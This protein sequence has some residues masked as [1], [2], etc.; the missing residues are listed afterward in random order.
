M[1]KAIK[2][3]EERSYPNAYVHG[4]PKKKKKGGN[5]SVHQ[6]F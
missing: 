2:N 3:E 5:G 6:K 4:M 1:P